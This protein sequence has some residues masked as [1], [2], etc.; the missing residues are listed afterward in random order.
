MIYIMNN[1]FSI[2][3]GI[4]T[5]MMDITSI[6]L[7][8]CVKQN[9]LGIPATDLKRAQLFTD[10]VEGVLKSI[11]IKQPNLHLYEADHTKSV[12]IDLSTNTIIPEPIPDSI[13]DMFVDKT[14]KLQLI[15]NKLSLNYGYF[16]QE[17]PEQ[18]M[19]V[20]NLTGDEKV[21]EIGGNIGRNSLIIGYILNKKNNT[22]FVTLESDTEISKQ[23]EENR[24]NNR[25][26]FYI[27]N[28]ALS[29]KK[30]IQKDWDTVASDVLLPGY[31]NV[32]IISWEQLNQKYNI[33][34]DTLVL[35]CE[36]AFY[37]ILMDMPEILKNI[38][39]IIMENDFHDI[40]PKEYVDNVLLNN[41]FRVTYTEGGGWGPCANRF[42]EV[43]R[44][45]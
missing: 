27:E 7:Y 44:K 3:Y 19:A 21:L 20:S 10:P 18:L 36:G 1:P 37:Y 35:D 39:L 22:N 28:S 6:A 5:D 24:N 8:K 23:L 33:Q 17:Y 45:S 34:F 32:N 41:N 26:N 2:Y 40:G 16:T 38:K 15:H 29:K 11:F 14:E 4:N 25:L 31:K 9:I 12:Y 13:I 30:L 43:W 42:Y